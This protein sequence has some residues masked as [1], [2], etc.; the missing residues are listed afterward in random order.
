MVDE[1]KG[2]RDNLAK[3][4][5]R[6]IAEF[7]FIGTIIAANDPDIDKSLAAVGSVE[8]MLASLDY[9]SCAASFTLDFWRKE[10]GEN[11]I[12][13]II[14]D[15][16]DY[17][18]KQFQVK[19]TLTDVQIMQLAIKLLHAQ[20]YLRINELVFVLNNA[21]CGKYGPTYQRIGIDTILTWL[22]RFYED[23]AIYL[24]SKSINTKPD[25]ARGDAPWEVQARQLQAYE[26]E[27]RKKFAINNR[28]LNEQKEK[29]KM[30]ERQKEVDAYKKE[31]AEEIKNA[32][33][34]EK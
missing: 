20:P 1:F 3:I 7:K 23:S 11:L 27:Q 9:D 2:R 14:S 15:V 6:K 18:L 30:K 16:I 17:F 34:P 13:G 10:Y 32:K 24:E 8:N 21:I 5:D 25:E 19:E 12:T 22:G 26:T 31:Y 29:D 28:L 4:C 33:G